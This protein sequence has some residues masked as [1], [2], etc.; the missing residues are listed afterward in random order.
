[1]A[2]AADHLA[3]L[4]LLENAVPTSVRELGADRELLFPQVIELKNLRVVLTA[5]DAR[6]ILEVSE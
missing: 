2:V 6:M 4:D 5:V 3:L 1:V